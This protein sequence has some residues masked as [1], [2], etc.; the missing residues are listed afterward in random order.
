[1]SDLCFGRCC[2]A[3]AAEQR[4]ALPFPAGSPYE[5]TNSSLTQA[6]AVDPRRNVGAS[7]GKREAEGRMGSVCNSLRS[8]ALQMLF[9]GA[10]QHG[11]HGRHFPGARSAPRLFRRAPV[12]GAVLAVIGRRRCAVGHRKLG[13]KRAAMVSDGG[14]PA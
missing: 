11:S 12:G 4:A 13:R 10:L 7:S 8:E 3:R 1:M 6:A 5:R 14:P 9:K 2:R